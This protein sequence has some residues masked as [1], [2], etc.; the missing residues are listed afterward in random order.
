[1]NERMNE[2]TGRSGTQKPEDTGCWH[3]PCCPRAQTRGAWSGCTEVSDS[4]CL[5]HPPTLGPLHLTP[6]LVF[7]QEK[8]QPS[9]EPSLSLGQAGAPPHTRVNT[10]MH[11]CSQWHADTNMNAPMF[12][13]VYRHYAHLRDPSWRLSCPVL[14]CLLW[15]FVVIVWF[16]FFV[17]FCFWIPS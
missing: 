15:L 1:M 17:L 14:A 5:K 11:T 13:H 2:L 12:T 10:S 8:P 4:L 16:G 3:S 6:A 9:G 7:H